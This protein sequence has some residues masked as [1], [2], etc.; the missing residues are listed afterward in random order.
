MTSHIKKFVEWGD[1]LGV[2][3]ECR[4]CGVS[5]LVGADKVMAVADQHATTLYECP[6]CRSGWTIPPNDP[7]THPGATM[8]FDK[9]LKAFLRT[10]I[11]MREWE[12]KLGCSLTLEIKSDPMEG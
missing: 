7:A 12:K 1:I 5:L 9:E 2:K 8:G 6:A 4:K 10:L 3:F 11:N